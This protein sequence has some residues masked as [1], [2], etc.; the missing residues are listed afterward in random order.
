M[1]Y[2]TATSKYL[3]V[4][5]KYLIAQEALSDTYTIFEFDTLTNAD[6]TISGDATN[7]DDWNSALGLPSVE[8]GGAYTSLTYIETAYSV[9]ITLSGG[10][11]IKLSYDNFSFYD[12]DDNCFLSIED[13]GCITRLKAWVFYDCYSL[14]FA[15]L[16]YVTEIVSDQGISEVFYECYKLHYLDLG[17]LTNLDDQEGNGGWCQDIAHDIGHQVTLRIPSAM[18]DN[19]DIAYLLSANTTGIIFS[20]KGG[21]QLAVTTKA[22]I[23]TWISG[24]SSIVGDWN[25]FFNLPTNGEVF[26]SVELVTWTNGSGGV[27]VCLQGGGSI[28]MKDSAF[29]G[30]DDI[31]AVNDTNG[32]F[33]ALGEQ[34]L[35]DCDGMLTFVHFP[36][37]TTV[38]YET[39]YDSDYIMYIY[40]PKCYIFND[41]EAFEYCFYGVFSRFELD[42]N[43]IETLPAYTFEECDYWQGS[44]IM[45]KVT[46]AGHECFFYCNSLTS[47]SLP[48]L[49]TT[50]NSCFRGCHTLTSISL[51]LLTTTG[52]NCFLTC[53]SLNTI[54]LPICS[55]LGPTVGDDGVFSNIVDNSINLTIPTALMTCNAGNP[56]GDIQYLID[57]AQRNTVTIHISDASALELTFDD[58]ANADT[59]VGDATDVS[60]WNAFFDLP[61]NGS[62]FTFVT[63]DG[64]TVNLYGSSNITVKENLFDKYYHLSEV[65][66]KAACIVKLENQAFS[67]SADDG[68]D[69]MLKRVTLLGCLETENDEPFDKYGAFGGRQYLEYVNMPLCSSIGADMFYDCESLIDLTLPWD[70]IIVLPDYTFSYCYLLTSLSFP[71]V[72][73]AGVECF[74]ECTAL[75]SI[76]LPEL[77]SAV[78][79]CF[80]SCSSLTSIS[81]PV[82]SSLGTTVGDDSV[83]LSIV[84]NSINLTIPA[85]L[86]TCNAGNP[87]GDIQYLQANNT[88]T[89][90]IS[91]ASALELTFDDIA[92]ADLLVGDAA[93]VSDWNA[94][95][96]LPTNG[97]D[98][99]FVTIDGSTVN[100]YGGS[101]ITTKDSLFG[102]SGYGD[103]LLEVSDEAGCIVELGYNTFGQDIAEGCPNLIT[104]NLPAAISASDWA[105]LDCYSLTSVNLPVLT[106]AGI[107]CFFYSNVLTSIS[108]PLLTTAGD[109]CFLDCTALTSISLPVCSSLGTTVGDDSVFLSIVDNSINLTIP[110]ALMTCNAGNPDG[111][112]QYL[113][114]NNDVS[115]HQ[116]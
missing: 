18:K 12:Y 113:V 6:L 109:Q 56:D 49:T 75:I 25:S 69:V 53:T 92:N 47:I 62:D 63:I 95:F 71:N 57:P 60:D 110:A 83:F 98:F 100:L 48:Q 13:H 91:D 11:N 93:D 34:C 108:L 4:G 59:L 74:N 97:S 22:S 40:M 50:G 30:Y 28:T 37:V 106:T 38:D 99:T 64:S 89:I 14:R 31:L 66:D 15:I 94:F 79:Y 8:Y 7:V 80:S 70:Q 67:D 88:V 21:F 111:D 65:N 78:D 52:Y 107:G 45:P 2:L 5:N 104:L 54:S 39:F 81:L 27:T 87:D 46:T 90:H 41:D 32:T 101:G 10:S 102:D 44:I 35:R 116:V 23:D 51:P 43:N 105:I 76:S 33:T 26:T 68:S 36:E 73:T 3:T 85:A 9:K 114:A 61:T 1:A 84:D 82:C 42:W 20:D 16:P 96:D 86:M 72:T 115:I 58:I 103:K 77:T 19:A 55:S 112:I 17:S 29:E 24:D